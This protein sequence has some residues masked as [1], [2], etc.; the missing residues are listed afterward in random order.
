MGTANGTI[1]TSNLAFDR[2][3]MALQHGHLTLSTTEPVEVLIDDTDPVLY[4]SSLCI[5]N[6]D[7]TATVYLGDSNVSSSDY[8]FRLAP[9]TSFF[10]ERM[11]RHPGLFAISSNAGSKIAVI[12]VSM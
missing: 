5:Q 2:G 1:L 7:N 4:Y 9:D 12:R 3:T 8:G 6:I 11:P 10:M